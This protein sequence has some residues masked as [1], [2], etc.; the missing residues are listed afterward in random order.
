[1]NATDGELIPKAQDGDSEA[2]SQLIERH[3]PASLKLAASIL[4]DRADAEDEVQNACTKAFQHI[5]SFQGNSMFS[6][7][8]SR[9][10]VNQCLMRLRRRKRTPA[11]SI[12]DMGFGDRPME[13]ADRGIS[14]E[15]ELGRREVAAVVAREISRIPPLLREPLML[16]E[17]EER[18]LA[19]VAE[20]MGLS[21]A[22][23]KSRLLRA[24][25]E[26]RIRLEKHLGRM[27][28]AT[29]EA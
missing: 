17:V 14:P 9:I 6:T 4:R 25:K 24:R 23:V 3:Y 7:W 19:E 11:V 18:S 12:E 8:F 27:G 1:M 16:R 21:Q 28:P 10:V 20:R 29:L 2:F 26:L 22:A 13:F 15:R 5:G